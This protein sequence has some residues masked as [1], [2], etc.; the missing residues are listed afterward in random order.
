MLDN[1]Q[2]ARVLRMRDLPVKTG[3]GRSTIYLLIHQG[4]FPGGFILTP[5]GRAR[6]WFEHEVDAFL[7]QLAHF[8]GAQQHSKGVQK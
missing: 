2:I 4:K 7:N 5:G 6:G 1:N 3:L 8:S